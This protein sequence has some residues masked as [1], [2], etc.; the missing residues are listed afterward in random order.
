MCNLRRLAIFATILSVPVA[1]VASSLDR[2]M[3]ERGIK[4]RQAD[5]QQCYTDALGWNPG[6]KGRLVIR[7]KIEADGHVSEATPSTAPADRFPDDVM[8]QCVAD[9]FMQ[10]VFPESTSGPI[11]ITYPLVFSPA[12]GK[13][14]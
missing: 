3:I 7:F 9:Q 5:Y 2:A 10:M 6:L 8:A 4:K 13:A 1:A 11:I 14:H 12:P